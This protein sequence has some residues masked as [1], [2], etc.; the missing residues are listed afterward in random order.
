ML[1]GDGRVTVNRRGPSLVVCR[2]TGM[3]EEVHVEWLLAELDRQLASG[4]S[5][6]FVDAGR[7]SVLST[8]AR[9]LLGAWPSAARA[10]LR[11]VHVLGD[12]VELGEPLD[13]LAPTLGERLH[14]H[15]SA[16]PFLA[17]LQAHPEM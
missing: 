1:R 10:G 16:E 5:L 3:L 9:R 6:V 11:A 17:A 15:R 8:P 4:A 12:P 14:R 13:A 7:L 2:L